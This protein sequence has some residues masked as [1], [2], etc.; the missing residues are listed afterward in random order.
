MYLSQLHCEMHPRVYGMGC[1][2]HPQCGLCSLYHSGWQLFL[3]F[4]NVHLSNSSMTYMFL[5]III[6]TLCQ[7]GN[8]IITELI[9]LDV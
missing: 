3:T 6:K 7:E 1:N 9:N 5:M 8:T 2:F 4:E